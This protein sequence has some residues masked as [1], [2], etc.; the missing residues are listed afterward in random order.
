MIPQFG[1]S[2]VLDEFAQIFGERT[3]GR[4]EIEVVHGGALCSLQ[5]TYDT[6]VGGIA[7]IGNIVLMDQEKPFPLSEVATLPWSF[8]PTSKA[9]KAWYDSV[10]KKGYLDKEYDFKV[11]FTFLSP[12]EELVTVNPINSIAD[13]KGVKIATGGGAIRPGLLEKLGAVPVFAPPPD[14]YP[15]LQKGIAEGVFIGAPGI[16]FMGWG[17]FLRYT[18][19]P[20][21]VMFFGLFVIGMNMDAYN[22]L[23]DDVKAILAD[24]DAD[25]QFSV[26]LSKTTEDLTTIAQDE[27]LSGPGKNI[28]W[29]A[30]DKAKLG[31]AISLFWTDWIAEKEAQGLPGKKVID[32]FYHGLEALGFENPALGYT[33]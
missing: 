13:M 31:E 21:F 10:Y 5:K 4:Y 12:G 28:D 25:A 2:V 20:Y 33:P 16:K 15:M 9:T 32:E 26:K 30:A 6:V 11:L 19:E 7:D 1:T 27:F 24:I 14:V 3:G 23:P 18:H 22:K 29:S 8:M 17:E